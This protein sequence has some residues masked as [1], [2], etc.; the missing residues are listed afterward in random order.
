MLE[1]I[2]HFRVLEINTISIDVTN[3]K[4]LRLLFKV[5]HLSCVYFLVLFFVQQWLIEVKE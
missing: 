4:Q 3:V 1:L 2:S 5:E